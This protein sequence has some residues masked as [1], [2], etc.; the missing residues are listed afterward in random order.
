MKR[1]SKILVFSISTLILGGICLG[2]T[3][4]FGLFGSFMCG[5]P[6]YMISGSNGPIPSCIPIF[7]TDFVWFLFIGIGLILVGI[8]FIILYKK[9]KEKSSNE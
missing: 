6:F 8:V 7:S 1:N 5:K 4:L 2:I 9:D 3:L